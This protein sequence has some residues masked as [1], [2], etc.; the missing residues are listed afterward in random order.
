MYVRSA[1]EENKAEQLY[2]VCMRSSVAH[3]Q[4]H[5][6]CDGDGGDEDVGEIPQW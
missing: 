4:H 5:F 6:L 2:R 3:H 1:E